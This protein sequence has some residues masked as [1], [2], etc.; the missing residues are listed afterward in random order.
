MSSAKRAAVG[1]SSAQPKR[2][3]RSAASKAT[4]PLRATVTRRP[5]ASVMLVPL[6]APVADIVA[7]TGPEDA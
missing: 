4:I 5:T 1:S 6:A 3:G 2:H 7:V